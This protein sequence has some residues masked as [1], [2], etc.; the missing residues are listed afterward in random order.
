MNLAVLCDTFLSYLYI[1]AVGATVTMATSYE[2][3][4]GPCSGELVIVTCS[5][6]APSL[7]WTI[8]DTSLM[9]TS[10]N[11]ITLLAT[12]E[13]YGNRYV[14]TTSTIDLVFYQNETFQNSTHPAIYSE[15]YFRLYDTEFIHVKCTDYYQESVERNITVVGKY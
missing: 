9:L 6:M 4:D 15:M 14:I 2:E 7:R 10:E 12:S 5:V 8:L 11:T 13:G 3:K 1:H